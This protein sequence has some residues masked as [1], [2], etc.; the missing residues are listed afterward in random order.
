[1]TKL[2]CLVCVVPV[3]SLGC[4]GEN[5]SGPSPGGG[6]GQT[7]SG[8]PGGVG[9]V[10]GV[11]TAGSSGSGDPTTDPDLL[12]RANL[13]ECGAA[14]RSLVCAP[15]GDE[16]E[17]EEALA[18]PSVFGEVIE[19]GGDGW[20]IE[21]GECVLAALRDR[22]PGL[23]RAR[24]SHSHTQGNEDFELF[25]VV[26]PSGQVETSTHYWGGVDSPFREDYWFDEYWPTERCDPREAE[27]FENCLT[28]V[29]ESQ[30]DP[31]FVI[32]RCAVPID[33][34]LPPWFENCTPR[35]PT[36]E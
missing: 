5:R 34:E 13:I 19:G 3:L 16:C 9:G 1:M 8:G 14:G 33:P 26:T 12:D 18:C 4:A 17:S 7:G 25:F 6:A 23:Y 10:A 36:C 27:F 22:T 29:A 32:A 11:G 30:A 35:S 31:G 2:V 28:K 21:G 15:R 24:F 20:E